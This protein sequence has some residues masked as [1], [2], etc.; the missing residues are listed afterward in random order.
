MKRSLIILMIFCVNYNLNGQEYS[1]SKNHQLSYKDSVNLIS[2]GIDINS[3]QYN[4]LELRHLLFVDKRRKINNIIG[5]I[6]RIGGYI[7]GGIGL[8][9]LATTPAQNSGMGQGIAILVGASF[10]SVGAIGYGISVP[11][12]TAS[13]KRAFEKEFILQKLKKDSYN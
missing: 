7:Y 4:N 9:F 2:F 11:F 5:S 6:F 12:K 13:K 10:F 1:Y 8:L 3:N